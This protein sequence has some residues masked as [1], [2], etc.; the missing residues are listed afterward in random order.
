MRRREFID[1]SITTK[2]IEELSDSELLRIAA[3]ADY[4]PTNGQSH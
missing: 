2:P 4:A 3:G 1:A